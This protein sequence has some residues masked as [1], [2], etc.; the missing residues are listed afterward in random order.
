MGLLMVQTDTIPFDLLSPLSSHLVEEV[1]IPTP[2]S[3]WQR[4][5]PG[6]CGNAIAGGFRVDRTFTSGQNAKSSL[7]AKCTKTQLCLYLLG[8]LLQSPRRSQEK[9]LLLSLLHS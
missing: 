6:S 9:R 1:A 8:Q 2:P 7:C 5:H 3:H 4:I